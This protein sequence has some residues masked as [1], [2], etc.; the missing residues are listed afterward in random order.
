MHHLITFIFIALTSLSFNAVAADLPTEVL[1][2]ENVEKQECIKRYADNCV[3]TVCLTS[4]ELDCSDQCHSAA[5]DKC[6]ELSEE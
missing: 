5:E 6:E 3:T 2:A 1:G 4:E